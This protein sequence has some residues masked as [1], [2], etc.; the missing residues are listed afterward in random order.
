MKRRA[1]G[2]ALPVLVLLLLALGAG[3]GAYFNTYYN[4]RQ[5]Y[6]EGLKL[7][8]KQGASAGRTQFDNCLKISSKLLQFYP[9]SRWV[10]DTILMIG[11]CYVLLDQQHRALRKFEELEARFPASKRLP[12]MR[13]WRARALFQLGR[14]A[15]CRQELSGLEL[16][17][18]ERDD[19][20]EALRVWAD[21]HRAEGDLDRL[22]DAQTR[23]LKTARKRPVRGEIHARI[24]RTYAQL[25]LYEEA[26]KHY[27]AVKRNRPALDIQLEGR[28][29]EI[30]NLI[31]LGRLSDA[32][33]RLRSLRRDERFYEQRDQVQ[34]R[35]GW[36]LEA[37]GDLQGALGGW[38]RLLEEF[39]RTESSAAA[40]YSIGKVYLSAYDEPDSARAYY[41]R[42]RQE[43]GSGAWADSSAREIAVLDRLEEVRDELAGLEDAMQ[44]ARSRLRPDSLRA[45]MAW[46]LLPQLR[47]QLQDSLDRAAD[48]LAVPPDTL[49]AE[50]S[51][52]AEGA[53]ADDEERLPARKGKGASRRLFDFDRR[54]REK[55]RADSLETARVADSLA[56]V[57]SRRL[58]AL[59]DSVWVSAILDTLSR[60]VE[61][62]SAAVFAELDSLRAESYDRRFLYA[63]LVHLKLK[64]ADRADSLLANLLEE[65]AR[66]DQS[67]RLLYAYGLLQRELAGDQAARPWFERLLENYPLS[68]AANPARQ[69]LGLPPQPT[70]E[71]SAA[72]RLELAEDLWKVQDRPLEAIDA[73]GELEKR[74]PRT[75]QAYSALIAAGTIAWDQFENRELAEGYFREAL[76][77]FPDGAA[78]AQL[79]G[80]LGLSPREQLEDAAAGTVQ[81]NAEEDLDLRTAQL[82]ESGRFVQAEADLSLQERLERLRE[83]FDPLGRL[84][85]QHIIN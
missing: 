69:E 59:R 13:V 18:L 79:R 20:V 55:V 10:D 33:S 75:P 63:E 17:K 45:R 38:A 80:L 51:D 29:G 52:A 34:L 72:V 15:G 40:A 22:V 7:N 49:A 30:D 14:Y 27:A 8:R 81:Q 66:P 61:I 19:R 53:L 32:R 35:E 1:A 4:A 73:Y 67:S 83:R 42:S 58:S 64:R 12:T 3:C 36:L 24:A 23:L 60:P 68:L 70:V 65:P 31:R 76:R 46:R 57:E 44:D 84:Q 37:D 71:D 28:L 62:D 11:Q 78:E 48:S 39:P 82:D 5:A 25:G 47:S 74:F 43:R 85:L 16:E 9:E 77:R 41:S 56:Q 50:P 26:V 21:L 6:D 2:R 54:L